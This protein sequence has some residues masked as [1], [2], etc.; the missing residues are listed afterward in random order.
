[1][2]GIGW[3]ARFFMEDRTRIVRTALGCHHRAVHDADQELTR[4]P[5]GTR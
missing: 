3:G 4:W 2:T 5:L 1:M